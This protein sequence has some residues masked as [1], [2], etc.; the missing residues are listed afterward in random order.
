MKFL[1]NS[2]SDSR[3]ERSRSIGTRLFRI[4]NNRNVSCKSAVVFYVKNF[5]YNRSVFT[6]DITKFYLKK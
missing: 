6:N 4:N 1:K 2:G 5:A 3:G